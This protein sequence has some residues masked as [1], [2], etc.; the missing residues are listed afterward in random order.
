LYDA[1]DPPACF[2]VPSAGHPPSAEWQ[3]A[4]VAFRRAATL[5]GTRAGTDRATLLVA[6]RFSAAV[7]TIGWAR[8]WWCDPVAL[9]STPVAPALEP[10][11]EVEV[12]VELAVA[13]E[14]EVEPAPP[15]VVECVSAA[16][17]L[18]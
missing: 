15:A 7:R 5:L 14:V 8:A 13:A 3:E 12:D 11:C 10:A 6:A 2:T 9:W 17:A 4:R 1:G 18:S 16:V